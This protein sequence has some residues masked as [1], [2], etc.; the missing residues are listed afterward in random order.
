MKWWDWMPWS[1]FFRMLSFNPTFSLSSFTFIKKLFCSSSLSA[2]MVVLSAHLKL[3]IFLLAIL[4]LAY[5]SFSL[6]FDGILLDVLCIRVKK[7]AWQYTALMYS[8]PSLEPICCSMSGSNSCFLA[9]IPPTPAGQV[10]WY[11]HLFQNFAQFAMI[12][13]VKG[14]GIVNKAEVDVFRELSCFLYDPVDVSSLIS[15]SSAFV[16]PAWT[17]GSSWFMYCCGLTWRILS[18]SLLACEMSAIWQKFERSLGLPFFGTGTKID[19]FQ[20]CGHCWV[21]QILFHI[22]CST[23]TASSFRIWVRFEVAGILSPP[24]ALFVVM[25]CKAH[26][27]WNGWFL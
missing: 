10:V 15:G 27:T 23:L 11:S 8:F 17:S 2:M 20:S 13:T 16:N 12:H 7:A 25:L 14:F 1:S 21:F 4:I 26:L 22:G 19:F 5:P 9:C 24:L 18:I 3:F 6:L